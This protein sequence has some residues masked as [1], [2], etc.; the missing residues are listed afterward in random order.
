MKLTEYNDLP[1]EIIDTIFDEL[2]NNTSSGPTWKGWA[3]SA[4]AVQK[5]NALFRNCLQVSTDFRHRI[6]S[7][8]CSN[9][10]LS[11]N[12]S[13]THI[14]RL[15]DV[16][17]QPRDSRLG[18]IG[19]YIKHFSIHYIVGWED[20]RAIIR[21]FDNQGLVDILDGLHGEHFGVTGFSF[22]ISAP[23]S[24]REFGLPWADIPASFRSA[25]LSLLRSPRLNQL[26]LGGVAFL[27]ENI[28][29]GSNLNIL[30]IQQVPDVIAALSHAKEMELAPLAVSGFHS[31]SLVELNTDHSLECDSKFLPAS[32]LEKLKVFKEL[33]NERLHSAK[34]W[35][36]LGLS[37]S[38]LTEIYINHSG[39]RQQYP[40]SVDSDRCLPPLQ[41]PSLTP[42]RPSIW[43]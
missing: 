3:E 6:L 7:R 26:F 23:S 34:T 33:P 5:Q 41:A 11:P 19:C 9:V 21:F 37:A 25:F 30:S 14:T 27:P 35:R 2:W 17:S 32:M 15:R 18:G 40:S 43:V 24:T 16:I 29:R 39:E 13:R 10:I 28:F 38:S 36:V 1:S 4:Q 42:L 31:P 20:L 12:P 8:A 22:I